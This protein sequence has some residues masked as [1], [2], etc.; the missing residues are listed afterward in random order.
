M[1][2][3]NALECARNFDKNLTLSRK[4]LSPTGSEIYHA[5]ERNLTGSQA[6]KIGSRKLYNE[7]FVKFTVSNMYSQYQ[8]FD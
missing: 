8:T 4:K 3:N 5:A 2:E 7:I 6:E 1:P